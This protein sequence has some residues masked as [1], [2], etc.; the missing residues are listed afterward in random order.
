MKLGKYHHHKGNEYE[1]IGIARDSETL[2]EV[3][4]YKALYNSNDFGNN[5]LW[6][7][8]KDNFL[9]K[10]TVNGKNVSR[11]KYIKEK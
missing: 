6:V 8:K 5:T 4:V 10:V 7:R 3:V 11:F 2:E 9:S 1:V